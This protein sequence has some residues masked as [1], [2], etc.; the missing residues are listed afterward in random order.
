MASRYG[1]T[2]VLSAQ[3]SAPSGVSANLIAHSRADLGALVDIQSDNRLPLICQIQLI[4]RICLEL[5][6]EK[7]SEGGLTTHV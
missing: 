6:V 2:A 5:C 1:G 4:S 7:N 3:L